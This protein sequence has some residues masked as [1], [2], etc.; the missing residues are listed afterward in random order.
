MIILHDERVIFLKTRKVAGTSFEIALSRFAGSSDVITPIEKDDEAIRRSKGYRGPQ[1]YRK[2]LWSL[3][4]QPTRRDFRGLSR[5]KL[6][7]RFF[8]HISAK[9]VRYLVGP[10][11]WNSYTKLS[12]IRDPWDYAVSSYFWAKRHGDCGEFDTW[13][14]SN[15]HL[16]TANKRQYFIDNEYV[17]D[18]MV[19]Y[20]H[21]DEDMRALEREKPNLSGL[22]ED[23]S[24]IQA[25]G[26]W[27]PRT[28]ATARDLFGSAP[29]AAELIRDRCAFEIS[30]FGYQSPL[31]SV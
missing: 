4:L 15:E 5:G 6:P 7:A 13:C 14:R 20:E 26:G 22:F 31:Q 11:I 8:P 17:I 23:F 16:L 21:F 2:P 28:G 27:R 10:R 18:I 12:I 30:T 3:F 24:T 29:Q 9:E 25:K 19:R 1:N